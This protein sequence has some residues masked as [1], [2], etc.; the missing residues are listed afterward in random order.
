MTTAEFREAGKWRRWG[1]IPVVRSGG[2]RQRRPMAWRL[3]LLGR[4]YEGG[5]RGEMERREGRIGTTRLLAAGPTAAPVIGSGQLL[6]DFQCVAG[7]PIFSVVQ[8]LPVSLDCPK[9]VRPCAA[10][11]AERVLS[12]EHGSSTQDLLRNAGEDTTSSEPI[13]TTT[14]SYQDFVFFVQNSQ[15]LDHLFVEHKR[16]HLLDKCLPKLKAHGSE[17]LIFSEEHHNM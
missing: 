17:V 14:R 10:L 7:L 1:C 6:M 11:T 8:P 3:G 12:T 9:L 5:R 16:R 2:Q 13:I 4:R 15:D